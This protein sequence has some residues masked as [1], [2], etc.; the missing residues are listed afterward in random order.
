MAGD[1]FNFE[2]VYVKH[3]MGRV[4]IEELELKLKAER[5]ERQI[6]D[7]KLNIY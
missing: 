6:D 3:L 5:S 4:N 2:N 7:K 1:K